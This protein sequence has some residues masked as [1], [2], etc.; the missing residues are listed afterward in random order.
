MYTRCTNCEAVFQVHASQLRAASGKVRCGGCQRIFNALETLTDDPPVDDTGETAATSDAGSAVLGLF[1][2]GES[3]QLIPPTPE[4]S[5]ATSSPAPPDFTADDAPPVHSTG[6][7]VAWT[8]ATL[9]LLGAFLLQ[10][11]W[12]YRHDLSQV[13]EVRPMAERL[14]QW[15][16]CGLAPWR[17]PDQITIV[18]RDVRSYA[19]EPGQLLVNLTLKN[20][21][22]LPQ[23]LPGLLLELL[24]LDNTILGAHRLRPEEY[25]PVALGPDFLMPPGVPIQATL[26]ITSPGE[27]VS[28]YRFE[29][30]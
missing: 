25:G 8:L 27:P 28:G 5:R 10:C 16:D 19:N 30:F 23:P 3:S 15:V 20:E 24:H 21:A 11:G 12:Y 6:S 13:A 2:R 1:D 17:S 4:G 14:C 26:R 22:T 9:L 7:T 18:D 29:V